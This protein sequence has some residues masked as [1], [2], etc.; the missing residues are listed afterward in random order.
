MLQLVLQ[1]VLQQELQQVLQQQVLQLEL[2]QFFNLN[3]PARA[4]AG[5]RAPLILRSESNKSHV[6][7]DVG[8][9]VG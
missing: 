1:P 6:L 2:R 3:F 7:V 4:G 8:V 9:I 5:G